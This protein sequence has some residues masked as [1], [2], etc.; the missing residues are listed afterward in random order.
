LL[1]RNSQIDSGLNNQLK[2]AAEDQNI[3]PHLLEELSL[4]R[5]KMSQ[6]GSAIDKMIFHR[7]VSDNIEVISQLI[8]FGLIDSSDIVLKKGILELTETLIAC[9]HIHFCAYLF[10]YSISDIIYF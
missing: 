8:Q 2:I 3:L 10:H 1:A 9:L 5:V 7:V 6:G 4:L